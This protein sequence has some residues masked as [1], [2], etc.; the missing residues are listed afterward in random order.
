MT[1]YEIA[2]M[3][4]DGIGVDVTQEGVKVLNRLADLHGG[5]QF[6][7]TDYP[8]GC[9]YYLEHGKMMDDDALDRLRQHHAIFLGACGFPGVPDHISL[10]GM[11]LSIRKAFDLWVNLRPVRLLPG[12]TGPLAERTAEDIDFVIIR[13]N[14]EGEYAGVGGRVQVGTAHEVASQTAV[15]TR[16]ATERIIRYAFEY[17]RENGR[18][19]V[20]SAT[21]SN[22]CQYSM[23]FWDEVFAEVSREFPDVESSH[24]H[25]DALSARFVT[26]PHTL[27]V[28]VGSNLFADILSDLGG[29][30]MGSLGLP[31]SANVN[32]DGDYPG[33]FEPVHGSAPDIAGKGIAN[34]LATIWSAAMMLDDLGEIKAAQQIMQAI[35]QVTSEGRVRT[36]DLGGTS[37]TQDMGD[38]VAA[39]LENEKYP[40]YEG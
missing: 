29:A 11:L 18:G 37:T 40:G 8:Y 17:A 35:E 2:L 22:A 20:Q 19:A 7:F 31:P 34:P 3:P 36:P 15:F 6:S 5:I 33:V 38:A 30:L 1:T 28:V 13:E 24:Y 39:A 10:W 21:K 23:V 12:I 32:P 14:T 16:H 9:G 26:H 4:G 27:D 25:V